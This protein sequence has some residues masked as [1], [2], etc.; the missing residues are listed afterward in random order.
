MYQ[1]E[2]EK[3]AQKYRMKDE[4][5]RKL[6]TQLQM[7]K[8]AIKELNDYFNQYLNNFNNQSN[9]F[10]FYLNLHALL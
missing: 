2:R 10:L 1:V 3:L 6:N 4:T 9:Y 5:I 8:F 7:N